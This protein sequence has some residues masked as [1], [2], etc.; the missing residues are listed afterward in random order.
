[1]KS[2]RMGGEGCSILILRRKTSQKK[3]KYRL[4]SY[5]SNLKSGRGSGMPTSCVLSLSVRSSAPI[6][7]D[8]KVLS[9]YIQHQTARF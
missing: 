4:K 5:G 6:L 8:Y 1:M 2:V 9:A 3:Y 7:H